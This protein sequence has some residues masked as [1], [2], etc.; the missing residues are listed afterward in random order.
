VRLA[1][2]LALTA[3]AAVLATPARA[4]DVSAAELRALAA[5]AADDPAA[6]AELRRVETVD[7]RPFDAERLFRGAGPDELDRRLETLGSGRVAG[8]PDPAAARDDARE[9]LSERRFREREVPRP[10]RGAL[11]WLADQ[12]RPFGEAADDL[13]G[14]LAGPLPGGRS[15]FWVLVS[16]AVLVLAAVLGSRL[17][18]LRA[19]EA[20]E[21]V[22]AAAA[23]PVDPSRLEREADAAERRGELE[24]ALRLRFRAGLLRLQRADAIPSR[25][26]LTSAE[27]ARRL[28]SQD[29]DRV[30]ASF[31][32]VVY[33]RRPAGPGDAETA[34]AGWARV[35]EQAGAR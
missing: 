14:V 17:V 22:R 18:R 6:L 10:L 12:L 27:V 25:D 28:R 3:V 1:P 7:G 34:R 11:A 35:L 20:T 23:G 33:G 21:R 29:F 32:E 4:E 13:V 5:R 16:L 19:R 31:D 15:T 8:R 2:L 30:A 9:I 24:R 26:S